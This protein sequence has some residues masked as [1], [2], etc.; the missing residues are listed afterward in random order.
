MTPGFQTRLPYVASLLVATVLAM[1]LGLSF[2][3]VK[4]TL[5]VGT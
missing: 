5:L 1:F 2:L 3:E 4:R